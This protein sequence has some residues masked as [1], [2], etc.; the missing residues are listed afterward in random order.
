M[1]PVLRAMRRRSGIAAPRVTVRRQAPWYGLV[2]AGLAFVGLALLAGWGIHQLSI[3]SSGGG[4]AAE[5]L[6][7]LRERVRA[8]DTENQR[9][10]EAVAGGERQIQIEA[11]THESVARQGRA[12]A[13]ENASLREDLAFFQSMAANPADGAIT[14]NRFEMEPGMIDGD[15]RFRLLVVQ[16]RERGRDFKGRLQLAVEVEQDGARKVLPVPPAGED[17]AQLA[18]DF[19][20]FQRVEG[21][22]RVP[23]GSR[24]KRVEVLV[25]EH[26][27]STAR[28]SRI[29]N[30]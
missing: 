28:T 18:L 25:M 21:S 30:F 1:T 10:R 9:L 14:V 26:G 22:F 19:R 7:R 5:E 2:L 20:F 15:Q 12:L 16:P 13:A 3:G 24:V 23:S 29:F 8:L 17:P 6:G 27:I 4:D 11:A